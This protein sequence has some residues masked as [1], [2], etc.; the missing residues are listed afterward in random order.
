MKTILKCLPLLLVVL[1][2]LIGGYLLAL[3]I[4]HDKT[5]HYN[6]KFGFYI[7]I[8]IVHVLLSL[9]TLAVI[10]ANNTLDKW[11]KIDQSILVVCLSIFGIWIWYVKH[12]RFYKNDLTT[13]EY[14]KQDK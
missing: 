7:V 5:F 3:F 1:T 11:K 9:G 12:Y 8:Q 14:S 6:E 4:D 2:F 13:D 10:W